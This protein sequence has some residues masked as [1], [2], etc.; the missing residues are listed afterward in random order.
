VAALYDRRNEAGSFRRWLAMMHD[1]DVLQKVMRE[2]LPQS[3]LAPVLGLY[4]YRFLR[5][6]TRW[7]KLLLSRRMIGTVDDAL[8]HHGRFCA[9]H[10]LLRAETLDHDMAAFVAANPGSFRADAAQLLA[11]EPARQNTSGRMLG[12]YRDYYDAPSRTLVAVR[13]RFFTGAFGSGF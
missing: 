1:P 11:G 8:R 5:V 3:G 12:G 6:T 10:D 2:H 4:T 7:P 9:Y 13:D